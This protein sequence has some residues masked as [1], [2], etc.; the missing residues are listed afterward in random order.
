ML[1]SGKKNCA[2]RDKR[3]NHANSCVVRKK[4]S[5]RSKKPCKLN[6]RSLMA[7][8]ETNRAMNDDSGS[9]RYY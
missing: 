2:M 4:N 6:G 3:N 9:I 8:I 5:E 1:N 7:N